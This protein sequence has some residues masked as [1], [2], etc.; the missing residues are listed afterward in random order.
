[1][2]APSFWWRASGFAAALL[3]PAAVLYGAV[4]A[5]RMDER[6]CEVGIPVVCIGN[7]TLGGAGKTPT[8]LTVGRLLGAA[9]RRPGFLT[10]GYGGSLDGPIMV[11][12]ARHVARE[13]GDEALL[14]ARAA[15][16]IVSRDRPAGARALCAAGTAVVV[17]DDGFQ[18]PSLVKHLA[19]LV[20]DARRAIG[21]GRVFPAGPLRAPLERQLARA[22]ALVVI[23][24]GSAA[25][26]VATAARA[27]GLAVFTGRLAPDAAAVAALAGD[28]VLAFAGIGDPEKFFATLDEAGVAAPVRR[29]FPDHYR[30]GASDAAALL[31]EAERNR[32][33][34]LTTEKDGARLAGDDPVAALARQARAL[35]VRLVLDDEERFAEFLL[36]GL[37]ARA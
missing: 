19:I 2:R 9:G 26:P 17:M 13:V 20:I 25:A 16:T 37:A 11:D 6:G 22:Q 31:A 18:N 30:Y 14:L 24:E 29:S 33:V 7:L 35:P 15:P 4:A 32:L 3:A 34:L 23:G 12:A 5:R 28:R 1:M 8:A 36:A 10:R 21:N 27:G